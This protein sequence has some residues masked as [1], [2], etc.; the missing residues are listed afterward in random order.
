MTPDFEWRSILDGLAA[1]SIKPYPMEKTKRGLPESLS[2]T[3][4]TSESGTT[5]VAIFSPA[6][7]TASK[8]LRIACNRTGSRTLF[9]PLPI[10]MIA[11]ER[12]AAPGRS[13][14]SSPLAAPT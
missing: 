5:L 14:L 1:S 8:T 7:R 12:S 11:D 4:S 9:S 13:M 6:G 3:C 2:Q 10:S